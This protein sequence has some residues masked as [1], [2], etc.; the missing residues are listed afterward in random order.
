MSSK[1]PFIICV[2][3][4]HS[5]S[6]KTYVGEAIIKG[7][8]VSCGA[9]KYTPSDLYSSLTDEDEAIEQE[10]KDTDRF[11]RAGA[12]NVQWIRSTDDDLEELLGLAIGKMQDVQLVIIEG[13][14]PLKFLQPD[15]HVFVFGDDPGEVKPGALS[16]AE[17]ADHVIY[18]E[19]P[20]IKAPIKMY[21]KHSDNEM[22]EFIVD[23][24]SALI[25]VREDDQ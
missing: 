20:S 6:G 12:V 23:V 7:V 2:T 4:A 11:R 24:N 8:N 19:K 14:S 10:G 15:L 25:S 21:N 5:G 17:T 16:L 18:K 9:I 22:N 13:N 1:R 3:G